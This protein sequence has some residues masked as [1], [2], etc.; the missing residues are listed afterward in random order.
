MAGGYLTRRDQYQHAPTFTVTDPAKWSRPPTPAMVDLDSQ[1]SVDCLSSVDRESGGTWTG[2]P[3]NPCINPFGISNEIP[4]PP[5]GGQEA[6]TEEKPQAKAEV[7]CLDSRRTGLTLGI[8][9]GLY[10][11]YCCAQPGEEKRPEHRPRCTT[12]TEKLRKALSAQGPRGRRPARSA[13]VGRG[14]PRHPRQRPASTAPSVGARSARA[15]PRAWTKGADLRWLLNQ[16]NLAKVTDGSY[17]DAQG[18][19]DNDRNPADD[20]SLPAAS[21]TPE[22][23]HAVH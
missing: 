13:V 9:I 20:P 18:D 5:S 2:S 23:R 4:H 14:L 8:V 12:S 21:A 7:V 19:F 22:A 1:S 3:P 15:T 10:N 6:V 17:D 16:E 11:R